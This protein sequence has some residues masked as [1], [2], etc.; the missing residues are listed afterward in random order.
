M[1]KHNRPEALDLLRWH[2]ANCRILVVDEYS[3]ISSELY[4]RLFTLLYILALERKCRIILIIGGD[5][6][7]LINL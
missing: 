2:M 1:K 6:L 3:Q 4:G 7:Q 5:S